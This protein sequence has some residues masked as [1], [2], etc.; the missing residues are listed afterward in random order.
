[1][2]GNIAQVY[3]PQ[4]YDKSSGPLYLPAMIANCVFVFGAIVCAVIL[5]LC[6]KRENRELAE[7]E[8]RAAVLEQEDPANED[9]GTPKNAD[10]VVVS[11]LQGMV[12]LNR[13]FRYML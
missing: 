11:R 5:L 12:R 13:G 3:S 1:M 10:N 7:A 6:L 2:V 9:D 8:A 4:L